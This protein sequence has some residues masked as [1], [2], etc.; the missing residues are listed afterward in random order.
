MDPA[1][2]QI[3]TAVIGAIGLTAA[4]IVTAHF[5]RKINETHRTLTTNHHSS[6]QPTV[7]DELSD[8]RKMLNKHLEDHKGMK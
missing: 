6:A 3:I 4:A 5:G 1:I 2:A 8:L 7:R